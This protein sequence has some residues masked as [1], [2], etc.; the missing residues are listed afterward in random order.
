MESKELM[1]LFHMREGEIALRKWM[2]D[3]DTL[4]YN[5]RRGSKNLGK[6]ASGYYPTFGGLIWHGELSPHFATFDE[7]RDYAF[8]SWELGNQCTLYP[9]LA[10]LLTVIHAIV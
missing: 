5:E 1:V 10:S 4:G 3:K 6:L 9:Y 8:L 2:M 7:L